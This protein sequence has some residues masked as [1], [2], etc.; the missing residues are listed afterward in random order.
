MM[1]SGLIVV[2]LVLFGGL[3][4]WS[5]HGRRVR[6]LPVT[7]H[8]VLCPLH[9]TTAQVGVRTDASAQ[10]CQQYVVVAACS[11]HADAAVRQ[12]ERLAYLR[13]PDFPLVSLRTA[14]AVVN[15]EPS[16]EVA[17]RQD[18]V[19]VLNQTSVFTSRPPVQ[20]TSSI[21]DAIELERQ[22]SDTPR[23]GR[24]LSYFGS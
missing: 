17:C 7:E 16:A 24:L 11:L 22:V 14:P 20:C 13:D 23:M 10:P 18:C 8:T 2:A 3:A 1:D 6:K 12:P 4:V 21:S 5:W 19:F 15:P 9:E